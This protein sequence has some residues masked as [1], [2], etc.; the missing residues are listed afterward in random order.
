MNFK[1]FFLVL[2]TAFIVGCVSFGQFE[3]DLN[4]LV[5]RN[6]SEAFAA[7][8][9]PSGKQQFGSDVV[10]TWDRSQNVPMFIPQT[11]T[12]TGHVGTTPIYG[13]TTSSQVVPMSFY[14]T[15]KVVAGSDGVIKTWD[16]D[17]NR[18]GCKRYIERLN[19]YLTK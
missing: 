18:G 10:Y 3:G 6:E 5:G 8:G 15:V 16:Y 4:T 13:T 12:T 7:F 1:N 19:S 9:Y 11:A 2:A 17:G 14:C